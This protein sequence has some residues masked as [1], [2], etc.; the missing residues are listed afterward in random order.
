MA[1]TRKFFIGETGQNETVPRSP[2]TADVEAESLSPEIEA[3]E[4]GTHIQEHTLSD[5]STEISNVQSK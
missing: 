1:E 3:G 5:V 4:N 2:A